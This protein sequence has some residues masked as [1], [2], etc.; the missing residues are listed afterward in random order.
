MFA[1]MYAKGVPNTPAKRRLS[2]TRLL[3]LA[4]S[5]VC[6]YGKCE[7]KQSGAGIFWYKHAS[8]YLFTI[9]GQHGYVWTKKHKAK[10]NAQKV[11]VCVHKVSVTWRALALL[12]RTI[13]DD[14]LRRHAAPI[15]AL[16]DIVSPRYAQTQRVRAT[17]VFASSG[18][19]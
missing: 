13:C 14:K 15:Y 11:C 2:A 3:D 6:V 7:I 12:H 18:A 1:G 10:V 17:C 19:R 5:C 8:C 9:P 16:P 4:V